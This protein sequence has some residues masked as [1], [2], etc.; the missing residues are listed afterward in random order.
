MGDG[1]F[2]PVERDSFEASY[3]MSEPKE[4]NI[5][6]ATCRKLSVHSATPELLQL[7]T[8]Y[9]PTDSFETLSSVP[10]AI[11]RFDRPPGE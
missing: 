6:S 3:R 10:E 9:F 2:R 8:S 1:G 7:L 5:Q 4:S 11:Q